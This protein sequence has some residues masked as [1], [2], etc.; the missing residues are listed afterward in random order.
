MQLQYFCV[1]HSVEPSKIQ[2]G[3]HAGPYTFQ[4]YEAWNRSDL[5]P[6]PSNALKLLHRLAADRG[7]VG[8]MAQHR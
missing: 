7:I 1:V 8:I 6:E 2:G 3:V 5:Q 4:R